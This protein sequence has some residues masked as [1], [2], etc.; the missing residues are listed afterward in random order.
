MR[1]II[2][3]AAVVVVA[4]SVAVGASS[5]SSSSSPSTTRA[6]PSAK[7]AR[8]LAAARIA[9]AKYVTN[10]GRAKAD[11]Y[12]IIT[13]MIPDMGFH[14]LNPAIKKFDIR[15][16]PIL[17]YERHN[18]LWQLGALEWVFPEKPATAP[19]P[20]ATYGSFGAACHYKDGTFVFQAD[21]AKCADHS[22]QSGSAFNFWH[23]DLVTLHLWL[24]YPNP[25]TIYT[26]TNAFVSPFNH[27]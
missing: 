20:G 19:L 16:P 10:L 9:T 25:D 14:Y 18:K 4:V 1:R 24:W 21:E 3:S 11:G 23:P 27:G 22:P 5:A 17:V 26:G 15:R 7:F 2:C 8:Q 6:R 12:G 13:K